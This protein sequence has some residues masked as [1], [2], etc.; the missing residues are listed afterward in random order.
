MKTFINLPIEDINRSKTFFTSL[1][2]SFNEAFC[3]DNN[4]AMEIGTD[5]NA[6]LLEHAKYKEFTSKE[7][8]DTSKTSE[9]IIALQ[10]DSYEDVD[11]MFEA[12]CSNGGSEARPLED[13]GFMYTHAFAD[14]DGHVWE[15]FFMDMTQIPED[16]A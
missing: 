13:L 15:P 6:M 8:A 3:S 7:I 5:V 1:G 11:S 14:P 2:F 4:L 10:L 9:V 16:K 12:A